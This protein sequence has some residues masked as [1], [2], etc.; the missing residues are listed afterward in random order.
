MAITYYSEDH[1]WLRVDGETATVG[2]TNYA[3]EQ[4]GDIIF[5]EL[6]AIGQ[7]VA[8]NDEIAVVESVKTAS[9]IK[10][11]ASGQITKT[12]TVLEEAPEQ[13]NDDP[14]GEGW[15]FEMTLSDEAQLSSLMDKAGY[16]AFVKGQ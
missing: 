2:I 9:D 8:Q 5:V 12:N 16:D 14:M 10:A 4:L 3:V 13:V 7:T 11:P 6:P 1:E 15:F